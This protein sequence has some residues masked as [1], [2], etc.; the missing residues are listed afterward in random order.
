MLA[1]GLVHELES[2]RKFFAT[3]T[4]VLEEADS[5]FAPQPEL[6]TVA[7]HVAHVADTIDWFIAGAFGAG[8]DMDFD[9]SIARAKAI[10]SLAE[11]RALLAKSFDDAIATVRAATD[12]QLATPIPN[13]TI[14]DG[15]PRLAVIG[16]I[17]DHTAHHRGALTVYA[18]LL[19]KV[20]PMP[21]A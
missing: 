15:A 19:G 16:G 13:D 6:Y 12:E 18:R 2:T 9:A 3:S 21:Y 7:G 14:M 20:S 17:V 4:S 1:A 8:W 5:G 11:A 10:T